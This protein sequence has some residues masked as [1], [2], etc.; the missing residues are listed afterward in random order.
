[1]SFSGPFDDRLAIR[2]LLDAYAEAVTLSDAAAWGA[3][4]AND[5]EW[6]LPAETGLGTIRG[7]EA[8][9]AV[10]IE[11]MTQFPGVLF[12]AWPG[13]IAVNGNHAMMRSYTAESFIQDGYLIDQRGRYDDLCLK[14][15]G[16]WVFQRRAFRVLRSNRIV[17]AT[18]PT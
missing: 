9:V 3:L 4:W 12:Q 2:E 15:G 7:R 5:G 1:M 17:V 11:A 16:A 13:S 18:V 10:W 14:L 6:A 8:I